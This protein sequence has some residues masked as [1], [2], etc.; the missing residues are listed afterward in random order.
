MIPVFNVIMDG[1]QD[2]CD[3]FHAT[4]ICDLIE[5]KVNNKRNPNIDQYIYDSFALFTNNK[6]D[7]SIR[8]NSR[9]SNSRVMDKIM[10][11]IDENAEVDPFS[12]ST[13]TNL[14]CGGTIFKLF[15]GLQSIKMEAWGYKISFACLLSMIS[16]SHSL[17]RVTIILA[18]NWIRD[19]W[20][21][22]E[23]KFVSMFNRHQF[24]IDY[25]P[26]YN[27]L[28]GYGFCSYDP[29][30]ISIGTG[31]VTIAKSCSDIFPNALLKVDR[32]LK[33]IGDDLW[34]TFQRSRILDLINYKL[35][36]VDFPNFDTS[37]W[38]LFENFVNDVREIKLDYA[39][40]IQSDKE[41]A[42]KIIYEIE[43]NAHADID[44]FSDSYA[45]NLFR[46]D[47]IFKLF[48]NLGSIV[49]DALP[50]K[51]EYKFSFTFLLTMISKSCSL[52]QITITGYR[53]WIYDSW[54]ADKDK[55]I[56]MFHQHQF[57][58]KY[59]EYDDYEYE[60]II[61]RQ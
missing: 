51:S 42:N 47:V 34:T 15:H 36:G 45:T 32:M 44:I 50:Y 13:P 58:I 38:K 4:M 5:W 40:L 48:P 16:K 28:S 30:K 18:E 17:Q 53:D 9:I 56:T 29:N 8:L 7:I 35:F 59:D 49:I 23:T 27:E 60:L 11:C 12:D 57:E 54:I 20:N 43:E 46:G 24:Y 14:F 22:Y 33:G 19:L 41:T 39:N 37:I 1:F 61:K 10:N 25:E 6:L 52:E 2:K 55:L 3:E 26:C 31:K 21:R